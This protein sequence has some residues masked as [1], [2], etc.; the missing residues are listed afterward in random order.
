MRLGRPRARRF[1]VVPL[2]LLAGLPVLATAASTP[3]T[4]RIYVTNYLGNTVSVVDGG[5]NA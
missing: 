4:T 1:V 3:G 5:A 2:A